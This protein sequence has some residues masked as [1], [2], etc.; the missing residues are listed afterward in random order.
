MGRGTRRRIAIFAALACAVL[1][2]GTALAAREVTKIHLNV[3][4]IVIDG[5]GG[6]TPTSLPRTKNA[7]ITIFGKGRISTLDG[8][9]P[10]VLHTLEFE[11]DR[12][13]ALDTEGLA[14]CSSGQLQSRNV[15]D[16][17]AACPNAI[18]GT[19][20]GHAV[21]A[22]ADQPP[23]PVDSPITIFNGPRR[24]GD[25][26][27]Y[28]HAYTTYPVPVSIV[29]PVRIER[30]SNGR[31]GYRVKATIPKLAGGA[32]IPISG[33]IRIGR[34]WTYRGK[35]HSYLNA[36]C[37]DGRLQAQGTFS[38]KDGTRMSGTFL[39]PCTVRG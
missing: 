22:L 27:V 21:A 2:A 38:F 9:L 4:N 6:Y 29:V 7:P 20:F 36:R 5:E 33:S 34:K 28:A 30:I 1:L 26:T 23:I 17:R 25:A 16:A 14:V 12:N 18:V 13:G 31:Y 10:P 32:G 37:A 15:K 24:G 11:F 39:R 8:Q 19:G 35:L 3:G